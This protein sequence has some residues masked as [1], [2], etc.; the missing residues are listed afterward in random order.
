MWFKKEPPPPEP[1]VPRWIIQATMPLLFAVFM[2]LVAFIANG[3]SE[4]LKGKANNETVI[5]YIQKQKET[6]DRQWQAIQK[7]FEKQNQDRQA[8]EE[9]VR[10]ELEGI[11]EEIR[12][13]KVISPPSSVQVEQEKPP[14]SPK[15]FQEYL[16]LN[17]EE[18]AAFRKLH[19][20][21]ATLPE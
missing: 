15:E 19:P 8:S 6:D 20:S 21:Y 1:K 9:S 17:K 10:K 4:D 14:L 13:K 12:S 3:F 7:S 18:R 11:R 16:K 2:G 5:L